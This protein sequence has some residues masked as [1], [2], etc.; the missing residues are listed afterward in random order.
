MRKRSSWLR[1]FVLYVLFFA[2][3]LDVLP[4]CLLMEGMMAPWSVSSFRHSRVAGPISAASFWIVT[5]F[6]RRVWQGK[7]QSF[8]VLENRVTSG[9]L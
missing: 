2:E 1:L 3:H 9:F 5:A 4:V 6:F 7:A 8:H